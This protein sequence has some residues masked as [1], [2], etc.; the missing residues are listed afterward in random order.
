MTKIQ[1]R[2]YTDADLPRL[3]VALAT[4]IQEAGECGYYHPG[5]IAHRIYEGY[6]GSRPRQELVQLWLEGADL[7]GF[8][9]NFVFDAGFL[10]FTSPRYRGSG[11]EKAM[12]QQAYETTRRYVKAT[13]RE[14]QSVI[15]DVYDCDQTRIDLLTDLGFEQYRTWDW[16]TERSLNAPI[17]E[18]RLPEGFT[19]RGATLDDF[20]Q[21]AVIRNNTFGGDWTPALY[22]TQ[23]MQSPGY[24]PENELVVLAPDGRFAAFTVIRLDPLNKVGLFEPV[25]THSDFR[26]LGLARALMTRG[27]REMQRQGMERAIVEHTA[28]NLPAREL[29][30]SLGFVKKY[31]TLGFQRG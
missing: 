29:Y 9:Y 2:A 27:L 17:A 20:A 15:T 19:I 7:I 26:R 30:L 12:L 13:R 16:I 11:V 14:D 23:V 10:L 8:A 24:Q 18:P 6:T 25:G 3:Q 5:N 1:P 21:L 31:E 4:W 28:E 22:R